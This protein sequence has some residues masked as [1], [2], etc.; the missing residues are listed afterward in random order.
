MLLQHAT[1][2]SVG[3]MMKELGGGS[4]GGVSRIVTVVGHTNVPT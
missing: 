1:M 4:N 3:G 2:V